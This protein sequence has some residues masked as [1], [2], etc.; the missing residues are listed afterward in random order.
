MNSGDDS[1]YDPPEQEPGSLSGSGDE[2]DEGVDDESNEGSDPSTDKKPKAIPGKATPPS[3]PDKS[4]KDAQA[5][6]PRRTSPRNAM[7]L[8]STFPDSP[9]S[10]RTPEGKKVASGGSKRKEARG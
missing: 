3:T 4:K 8:P 10:T 6:S 7:K 1:S 5:P 9:A 2:K